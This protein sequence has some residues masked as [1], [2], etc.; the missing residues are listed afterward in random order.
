MTSHT[1]HTVKQ[2]CQVLKAVSIPCG[3]W[4]ERLHSP[5]ETS[6]TSATRVSAEEKEEPC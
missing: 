2:L 4:T 3:T 6:W 5:T 1:E